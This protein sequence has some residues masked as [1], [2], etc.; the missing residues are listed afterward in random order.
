MKNLSLTLVISL[1]IS[2]F[3]SCDSNS[4][5]VQDAKE[6]VQDEKKDVMD[7]QHDLAKAEQ[8]SIAKFEEFRN[9][10]IEKI[11]EN[12]KKIAELKESSKMEKKDAREKTEKKIAELEK[13]NNELR[14]KITNY[15]YDG[16]S[17]W[18]SFK[19]EFNHDMEEL[20][21]AFKD[22]TVKNTK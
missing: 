16:K 15:K 20:G 21:H 22:L 4:S 7:A 17:S 1:F 5:K 2:A 12:D 18:E 19:I 14:A 6:K 3:I 8:D 13:R 11:N 10:Q 9:A